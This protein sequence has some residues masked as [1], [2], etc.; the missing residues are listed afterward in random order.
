MTPAKTSASRTKKPAAKKPSPSR[1]DDSTLDLVMRLMAVP[2]RSGEESQVAAL[3]QDELRRAGADMSQVRTD[4]TPKRSPLGGEIGN[5][6]FQLPGTAKAPRRLLVAH[7]DAV[8]LCVGSRPVRKG[9]LVQSADKSTGLAADNRA[10]CAAILSAALAILKHKLPHPPLTFL[11]CVQEEVGL[12]GARHGDLSLLGKPKLAFNWDGGPAEKLTIGAT[13]AFRM[14]INVEGLA[15]HAGGAPEKGISAV[16]IAALAIADLQNAGWLGLIEKDGIR[17]TSNVGVVTG[18]AA[19]NVVTDYLELRAECR[20][21]DAKFR[22]RILDAFRA[23]F[24][25]AAAS[26]TN[27]EGVAG[28]IKFESRQDYESFALRSDEPCVVEAERAVRAVGLNP[29]RAISNG[30]LDANWLSARGIPTV[31]L[32][33]G[34]Q[35]V[36]TTSERLDIPAFEYA[37]R[38]ALKLTAPDADA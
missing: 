24:E 29:V 15:S 13:G 8:P 21:H 11:W 19:T 23:A 4:D 1:T 28:K 22:K 5:L 12:F 16:T 30:G 6:T 35:N 17:G 26:V 7:M 36:H 3:I 25:K 37:C 32:G 2:G 18:G 20:A 34:Q 10:G 14:K 27:H 33:C 9:K 31:T 38:I